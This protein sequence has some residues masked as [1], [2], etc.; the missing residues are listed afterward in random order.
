MIFEISGKLNGRF[1]SDSR[2]EEKIVNLGLSVSAVL[3]VL[4]YIDGGEGR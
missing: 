3:P 1:D 4:C 2:S